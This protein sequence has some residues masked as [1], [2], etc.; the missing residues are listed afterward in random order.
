MKI[1][2][3]TY[4]ID[5]S[6][7][8]MPSN[9]QVI[10]IGDFD[11]VHL[12]HRDVIGYALQTAKHEGLPSAIMTFDPHPREVLGLAKYSHYLTPLPDRLEQFASLGVDVTYIVHFDLDFAKVSPEDFV[13]NMLQ[14]MNLH[15]VVVGFDFTFGHKGRGTVET[16]RELGRSAFNVNVVKPYHL[17][18]DK[19]S[20]TL[21]R[22]QLHLGNLK[23]VRRLL[24]RSYQL[25]GKVVDGEK[26]G[27]TIGFPT[28]N[29][30]ITRPYVVPGYGVYAVLV[31]LGPS[32]SYGVMNIGM[33]PTFEHEAW[34]QHTLE[35]HILDF[36]HDIYG[37]EIT[38]E[39]IDYI[40]KEEKFPSIEHLK[41]QIKADIIHAKHI[42]N[43]LSNES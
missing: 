20:S 37:E 2:H 9:S 18:G 6:R 27:R 15:T 30:E 40:R 35:V 34:N 7:V 38:I 28:A 29:I 5:E 13:N 22:E 24:G 33:K 42:F 21:I 11:G 8:Q 16:L 10:A 17:G 36:D 43:A 19:V 39:L 31:H 14:S 4:P 25:T 26:R 41:S 23:T 12:G 32:A 1:I 3:L